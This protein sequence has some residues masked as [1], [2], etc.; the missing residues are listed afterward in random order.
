[1]EEK[2]EERWC[3]TVSQEA[4]VSDTYYLANSAMINTLTTNCQ[5]EDHMPREGTAHP[6]S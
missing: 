6:H 3:W 2:K 5:W 4:W 1:M